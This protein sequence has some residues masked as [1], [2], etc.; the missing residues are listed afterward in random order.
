MY[1]SLS[2]L[3]PLQLV[4]LWFTK[5]VQVSIFQYKYCP[6]VVRERMVSNGSRVHSGLKASVPLL[7]IKLWLFLKQQ[8]RI[9][10]QLGTYSWRSSDALTTGSPRLCS[11]DPLRPSLRTDAECL[12][13]DYWIQGA[14]FQVRQFAISRFLNKTW[15]C[16]LLRENLFWK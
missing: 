9:P 11:G 3:P 1:S 13:S 14:I 12:S 6:V 4:P 16:L 5:E 10:V 2:P 7:S 8:Q 15:G